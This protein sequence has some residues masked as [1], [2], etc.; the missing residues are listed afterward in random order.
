MMEPIK[1]NDLS[2]VARTLFVPL[3]AR[4]RE[5]VRADAILRDPLAVE[6]LTAVG[7][8]GDSLSGMGNTDVFVIAMRARQFD[9]LARAFLARN[10]G[11]VVVVD[12]GCGL[13][14]R[15]DRLN[16]DQITWIGIDLPEVIKLR[17]YFLP[18]K[19]RSGTIAC[20]MFDTAWMKQVASLKK[21][22]L[23]LA[24][25][26]F[27]YFSAAEIKP[28]VLEM[29]GT[30][31]TGELA[32][33]AASAF[34]N[35]RH[36]RTSAVLKRT[37]TRLR[38]DVKNPRELESWGLCMLGKWYYFDEPEPRLRPFRWIRFLPFLAK[39]TGVFHFRLGPCL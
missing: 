23:F 14:T 3:A 2:P 34:I 28:M 10:P 20:S 18:D 32:F 33:E 24:E 29:A 4:A 16:N 39:V 6:L 35:R 31:P 30:F 37:G 27:P 5:S 38:W 15:F 13:D 7:G 12:L 9:S 8:E 26:V 21:P 36:N 11:G 17:R 25:G 22:V 19:E 1:I